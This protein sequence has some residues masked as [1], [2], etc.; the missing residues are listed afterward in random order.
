VAQ[1]LSPQVATRLTQAAFISYAQ[2][3]STVLRL[4]AWLVIA[5]A[6]LMLLFLPARAARET[7][8]AEQP[9]PLEGA[10]R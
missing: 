5:G 2:G 10:A 7:V 1:H 9:V 6:I 8:A 3:M 4:C